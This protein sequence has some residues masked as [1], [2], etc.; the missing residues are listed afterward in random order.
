MNA[1]ACAVLSLLTLLGTVLWLVLMIAGGVPPATF[2]GVLAKVSRLDALFYLTYLNAAFLV[3]I[4][5]TL[6]MAALYP[7]CRPYL[8]EWAALDGLVFVPVYSVLNLFAYLSQV[9]LVPL[10]VELH[11][12]A[13][14]QAAAEMLLRLAIQELPG[15][16]VAFF[17]G[18]AYGILGIPSIIFGLGLYRKGGRAFRSGGILLALNGAACILGVAGALLQNAL[19]GLGTMAG[20]AL[21]LLALIPLAWG[22]FSESTQ[23]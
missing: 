11:Q 21:F 13:V 18:L 17:N 23:R 10:L 3:T 4:P 2:E 8:P 1:R 16:M 5:A 19:L 14:Y 20:G 12:Q 15:S 7:M 6:L 9:T 22:F